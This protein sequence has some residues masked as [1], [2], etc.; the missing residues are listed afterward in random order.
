MFVI[1]IV[2]SACGSEETSD[3]TNN[4][5]NEVTENETND[6]DRDIEEENDEE[7]EDGQQEGGT[8]VGAMH[9]APSGQFNPIFYEEA[10][11]ANI[12]DF[13]HESLFSQN[14]DLEFELDGLAEDFEVNEEQ[15]EMKVYLRE[16][17]KW[18]DGEDF[19]A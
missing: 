15:T 1:S 18:H 5:N 4:T 19:T 9:T 13:T 10:Y 12:I 17:V 7:S 2:L 11:E 3:N 8:I 6:N 14:A 16:D